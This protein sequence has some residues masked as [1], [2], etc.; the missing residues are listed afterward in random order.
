MA[1]RNIVVITFSL[2]LA[3]G[4]GAPS[5][6]S[7]GGAGAADAGGDTVAEDISSAD[8]PVADSAAVTCPTACT[9]TA[10]RCIDG[11][12]HSCA[13]IEG[14]GCKQW[15]AQ[16]KCPADKICENGQCSVGHCGPGTIR[17]NG[18]CVVVGCP[19]G[20][21]K[22]DGK[23]V[24]NPCGE[25]TTWLNGTCQA[26]CPKNCTPGQ[27]RCEDGV[28]QT[29][30]AAGSED[31][32]SW[33]PQGGCPAPTVCYLGSCTTGERALV[34][35]IR[36][37]GGAV[38]TTVAFAP[39]DLRVAYAGTARSG[40]LVSGD[41]GASWSPANHG[42][43]RRGGM[44]IAALDVH[45][46]RSWEVLVAV[47][48]SSDEPG[49]I[50]HSRNGAMTWQ[51]TSKLPC[52]QARGPHRVTG[53]L[54]ARHPTKASIVFV[55]S[56][57]CG[58]FRSTNGGASWSYVGLMGTLL[59]GIYNNPSNPGNFVLTA[60]QDPKTGAA[61]GVW[62][63]NNN[64]WKK[65]AVQSVRTLSWW[66][67]S[68]YAG[69]EDGVFKAL[70]NFEFKRHWPAKPCK[71]A[72]ARVADVRSLAVHGDK[73]LAGAAD[74]PA[75]ATTCIP[76]ALLG[77][78]WKLTGKA[79]KQL[80]AREVAHVVTAEKQAL[81]V[82][83][84][85]LKRHHGG[86]WQE[87]VHGAAAGNWLD[88]SFDGKGNPVG[89]GV[90]G[91]AWRPQQTPV[92]TC[93]GT[94]WGDHCYK[95]FSATAK[96]QSAQSACKDWGGLLVAPHNP[97]ESR[98]AR[99]MATQACG[100]VEAWIGL[101]DA[102]TEGAFHCSDGSDSGWRGWLAGQPDNAGKLGEHF[103]ELRRDGQWNDVG[104]T[105][106]R[107]CMVCAKSAAKRLP[108]KSL[109][110][111]KGPC[112][113]A[114]I[115]RVGAGGALLVIGP[116][117]AQPQVPSCEQLH[118]VAA[119][120][121]E[122]IKATKIIADAARAPGTDH[123]LYLLFDGG[124]G[125][126][127]RAFTAGGGGSTQKLAGFDLP[128]PTAASWIQLRVLSKTHAM[129]LAPGGWVDIKDGKTGDSSST[130]AKLGFKPRRWG[131]RDSGLPLV[132]AGRDGAGKPA[133][134]VRASA[135]LPWQLLSGPLADRD[136]AALTRSD[137]DGSVL[138]LLMDPGSGDSQLFVRRK[139]DKVWSPVHFAGSEG[140][141]DRVLASP[142][143][144]F[145]AFGRGCT[146]AWVRLP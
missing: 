132:V 93:D 33:V 102:A 29:C 32:P 68:W 105:T 124:K 107:T 123:Y 86:T 9:E 119:K 17:N 111:L 16:D 47:G 63:G 118:L 50:Y 6:S 21:V 131:Q 60:L 4:C 98:F 3:A 100:S 49:A 90:D 141:C 121:V 14:D 122:I 75:G 92:M 64:K 129:V 73:L 137:T 42:L 37:A 10:A 104:A 114:A 59:S 20:Q 36:G 26:A 127:L 55:A 94:R 108:A 83:D 89:A 103:T 81:A 34:E 77:G 72:A 2:A 76:G 8:A 19:V 74:L 142:H 139:A 41:R 136:I 87:T 40:V 39:S 38:H 135:S 140:A 13:D 61:G 146:P 22:I 24:D 27:T 85:G 70:D 120:K 78:I 65:R 115:R 97:A 96:W 138:A 144:G 112:A 30:M 52:F 28:P 58:L 7:G 1:A 126:E 53:H 134:A 143:G 44:A 125:V 48:P 130:F 31:C 66:K 46:K 11:R 25:G 91:H 54:F 116:V 84:G 5:S 15:L 56:A 80:D 133:V 79:K 43:W 57:R 145:V 99:T 109:V 18:V 82:H 62:T 23:C 12:P 35:P 110:T 106:Q 45:P 117:S 67:S 113:D 101:S 95:A 128:E 71:V 51:L 88:V 69:A